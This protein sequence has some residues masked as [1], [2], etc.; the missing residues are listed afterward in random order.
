MSPDHRKLIV[1]DLS[2]F[3]GWGEGGAD[4]LGVARGDGEVAA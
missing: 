1:V 4:D 3:E 2:G